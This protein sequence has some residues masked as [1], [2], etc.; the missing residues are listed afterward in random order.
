MII[1]K[2]K[3]S[4]QSS[5]FSTVKTFIKSNDTDIQIVEPHDHSVDAAEPAVKAIKYHVIAGL[6]MVDIHFPLQL[7]NLSLA[8]MQD[9][10]N[11][12]RTSRRDPAK[13]DGR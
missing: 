11:L 10:S 7:W 3:T 13:S 5:M 12:L 8:Q 1:S 9:T 2:L 6:A 4:S